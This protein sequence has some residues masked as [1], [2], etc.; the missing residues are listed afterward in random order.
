MT[1]FHFDVVLLHSLNRL[2][3]LRK[4]L[5]EGLGLRSFLI[6]CTGKSLTRFPEGLPT[7]SAPALGRACSPFRIRVNLVFDR[8]LSFPSAS[9]PAAFIGC[10]ELFAFLG[11]SQN[12]L[13]KWQRR[14]HGNLIAITLSASLNRGRSE[15]RRWEAS[16]QCPPCLAGLPGGRGGRAPRS[17]CLWDQPGPSRVRSR[18]VLL[19]PG[20]QDL[21]AGAPA[22][23]PAAPHS[24]DLGPE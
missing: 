16:P 19:R 20:L 12:L 3:L 7:V 21:G 23:P 4:R 11:K 18:G 10:S 13:V 2:R 22:P 14:S 5:R 17:A 1:F 24:L 15:Q 9:F 8:D 6:P